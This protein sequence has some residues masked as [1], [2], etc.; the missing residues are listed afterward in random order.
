MKTT[1]RWLLQKLMLFAEILIQ[2]EQVCCT[3]HCWQATQR[4]MA[5]Q[6]SVSAVWLCLAVWLQEIMYAGYLP[7]L[8]QIRHPCILPTHQIFWLGQAQ[9]HKALL[10]RTYRFVISWQSCNQRSRM[11]TASGGMHKLTAKQLSCVMQLQHVRAGCLSPKGVDSSLGH[12]QGLKGPVY[13]W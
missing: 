2:G 5:I 1:Q 8:M 9:L 6:V 12:W 10:V 13:L 7:N 4:L 11:S 3:S